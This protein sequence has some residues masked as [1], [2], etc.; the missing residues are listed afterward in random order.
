MDGNPDLHAMD[1]PTPEFKLNDQ[2]ERRVRG[3]L[4]TLDPAI[5]GQH[6]HNTTLRMAGVLVWGFALSVDQAWPFAVEYNQRCEPPWNDHDLR[7]KLEQALVAPDPYK[8]PRGY[9]LNSDV[10]YD[11]SA[12]PPLRSLPK[13]EYKPETL[14]T[15]ASCVS[16]DITPAYLEARSKFTCWNRSPAGFLHKL[17]QP[18]EKVI[19]FNVFESQG[20]EVWEHTGPDQDLSALNYLQKGQPGV[21]FMANPVDGLY[22]LNPR[23]G[24]GSRRSEESVTSWRYFVI[25]SDKAQKDLWLKTLVQFPLPIAAIY[26]SG[27]DSIHALVVVNAASKAE[28]DRLVRAELAPLIVPFGAD[29]GAMTAVRLTRLPNCRREQT[30]RVQSLLYLNP[31]PDYTP[32]VHRPVRQ[33]GAYAA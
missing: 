23:Q 9:M 18:G 24:H 26:D 2:L 22:H 31:D 1:L 4:E 16:D 25:E 17:Y 12:P 8:R 3:Y 30:G 20:C 27:G 7:R 13:P 33:E 21:W 6:G 29:L 32:I 28:W 10:P 15:V 19:V 5:D 14:A 11:A